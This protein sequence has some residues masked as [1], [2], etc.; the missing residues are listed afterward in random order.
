MVS[1]WSRRC[2]FAFRV[3][4]ESP[5]PATSRSLPIQAP[6]R[7][8]PGTL[9]SPTFTFK[10][11]V[12]TAGSRTGCRRALRRMLRS[13]FHIGSGLVCL[14]SAEG[15]GEE[16]LLQGSTVPSDLDAVVC[17]PTT[18]RAKEPRKNAGHPNICQPN[19]FF[20]HLSNR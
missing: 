3:M 1:P 20:D 4:P 18:A 11:K 19:I 10:T 15:T 13:S 17:I 14:T 2:C 8:P 6:G 7:T 12:T 9:R 5:E 16:G